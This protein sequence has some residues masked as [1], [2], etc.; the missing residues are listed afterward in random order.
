MGF[1]DS[2]LPWSPGYSSLCSFET[3]FSCHMH[4]I[5]SHNPYGLHVP[6]SKVM[7]FP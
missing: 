4:K 2:I 6:P 5:P 1:M 3:Q 7:C